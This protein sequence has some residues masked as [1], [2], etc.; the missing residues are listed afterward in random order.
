MEPAISIGRLTL[1][2]G[3]VSHRQPREQL[4]NVLLGSAGMNAF[5]E[6][7]LEQGLVKISLHTV[8]KCMIKVLKTKEHETAESF[9]ITCPK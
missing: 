1:A 7:H 9:I 3:H 5:F 8:Y 2:A 4:A 6:T